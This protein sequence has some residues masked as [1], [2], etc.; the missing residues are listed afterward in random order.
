MKRHYVL[1]SDLHL[2]Q[3]NL[4][5]ALRVLTQIFDYAKECS[6]Q[7]LFL[8]DFFHA[9]G[10]SD[11]KVHLEP[12]LDVIKL[13]KKYQSRDGLDMLMIPGN[14]DFITPKKTSLDIF[15]SFGN[16]GIV[17]TPTIIPFTKEISGLFVPYMRSG[18]DFRYAVKKHRQVT[19]LC[20][21]HVG[22]V[23]ARQ[24]GFLVHED[25]DL[26]VFN[27]FKYVFSGHYHSPHKI[28]DNVEYLG[29]IL[30]N[31]WS[32]ACIN[33][34]Q[35]RRFIHLIVDGSDLEINHIETQEPVY[36]ICDSSSIPLDIPSGSKV[37]INVTAEDDIERIREKL[38]KKNIKVDFLKKASKEHREKRSDLS[39]S[40]TPLE[41]I[42]TYLNE[43]DLNGLDYDE[44]LE[45]ISSFLVDA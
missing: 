14:H 36:L 23:G 31:T 24:H 16:I 9:K 12:I 40:M 27:G 4:T 10:R 25:V 8:G 33:K 19:Q 45:E 7:I 20:F 30:Q 11:G 2:S 37:R 17:R 43:V 22:V 26:S 38:E 41:I 13:F 44:L 3:K 28:R 34:I 18:K 15:S 32:D 35:R 42:K 1:F 5:P 6:A 21:A 39:V 29:S